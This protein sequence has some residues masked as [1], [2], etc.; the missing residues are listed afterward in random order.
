MPTTN[1]KRGPGRPALSASDTINV[2]TRMPA[3]LRDW[4]LAEAERQSTG[5][6]RTYLADVVRVACESY[7]KSVN[8][9]RKAHD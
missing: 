5:G 8:A 9:G 7:R 6:R 4:L 2:N 3:D 1:P